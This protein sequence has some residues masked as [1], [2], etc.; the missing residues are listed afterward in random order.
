MIGKPFINLA[1][2]QAIENYLKYKDKKDDPMFWSFLVV[3]IRSLIFIYGELDIINPYITQ[4]EHNMGG[5]DSNLSKYGFS[6]E[7]IQDF[8]NQFL[9]FQKQEKENQFP[10][11]AFI[12]IQKYLI[13]MFFLKQRTMHME[14]Q[15]TDEFKSFLYLNEVTNPFMIQ[16]R[17]KYIKDKNELNYYFNSIRYDYS[18]NF[19][20]EELRRSVLIPESYMLA[21]YN[22]NQI[23]ALNDIELRNVNLRVYNFFRVNPNLEDRDDLL[24]KA[25]N[26]YKKYGNR[27]TSGNGYVDFLLFASILAT[28]L[29]LLVL[30]YFH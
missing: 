24:L 21:G 22:F 9:E 14:K 29:F 8:E 23:M 26:Y 27:V 20:L 2:S 10:N 28:A 17:D 30:V 25:V 18:H 3:V 4:N 1:V 16:D 5:F 15:V 7:K 6:L 12:M 11:F 13:Q 19:S